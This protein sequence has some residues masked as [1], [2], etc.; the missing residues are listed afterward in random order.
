TRLIQTLMEADQILI[1][2]EAGSH[3]VKNTVEDIADGFGDDSYVKKMV[4]LTDGVSPVLSPYVD[5]P[6]IQK[7][8]IADMQVRGMK[9]ALTTDF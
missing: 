8:F 3:C 1:A 6:A 4:M 5:F 7:Q 2:G 9:T